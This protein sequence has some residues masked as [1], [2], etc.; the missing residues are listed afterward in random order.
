MEIALFDSPNRYYQHIRGFLLKNEDENNLIIGILSRLEKNDIILNEAFLAAGVEN[1]MV[2]GAAL[3]IPPRNL[4]ITRAKIE[5][6]TLF[7]NYLASHITPIP[8]V[9]GPAKDA[10]AFANIWADKTKAHVAANRRMRIYRIDKVS[11]PKA[12]PGNMRLAERGDMKFLNGWFTA[13]LSEI[14]ESDSPDIAQELLSNTIE[15]RNL[16]LWEDGSA[17]SMAGTTRSTPNGMSVNLVYTPK[18]YRRRGYASNLV[19]SLSE[20]IIQSGK[21]FCTLFTDLD[22]PTSNHIYMNIGYYPVSDFTEYRI[23]Q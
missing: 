20:S 12:V 6:I 3:Y 14:E 8:G 5:V 10:Q 13:M 21:K 16:F 22:N 1:A 23:S 9:M 18:K 4:I 11:L 17:V 15:K 19:A 2:I 7:A